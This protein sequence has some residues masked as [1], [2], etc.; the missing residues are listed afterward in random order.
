MTRNSKL[1]FLIVA[2]LLALPDLPLR[3]QEAPLEPEEKKPTVLRDTDLPQYVVVEEFFKSALSKR[4]DRSPGR[5]QLL[6]DDLGMAPG[7]KAAKRFEAA[8][9]EAEAVLAMPTVNPDLDNAEDYW[10]FQ[11]EALREKAR[12]LGWVYGTLL[13]DLAGLGGGDRHL[14]RYIEERVRPNTSLW[15]SDDWPADILNAIL[16]FDEEVQAVLTEGQS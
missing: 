3:A 13:R 1:A 5:F 10:D 2:L 7:S 14:D 4:R 16:A 12:A 15:T 11:V 8:L 9:T 6:R